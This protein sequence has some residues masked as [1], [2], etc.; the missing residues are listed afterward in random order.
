MT[1][2]RP[3]YGFALYELGRLHRIWER[4]SEAIEYFDRS[5]AVPEKYRDVREGLVK[6]ERQRA[7]SKD[8]RY[9]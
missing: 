6:A 8:G 2:L 4:W 3:N 7:E 1:L 9:P 5:L